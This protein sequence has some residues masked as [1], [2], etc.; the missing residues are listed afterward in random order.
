VTDERAPARAQARALVLRYFR[1]HDGHAD[2]AGILRDGKTL[3]ALGRA[4]AEPFADG[5]VCGV[6]AVESRGFVLGAL[7]AR[8]LGVG[9]VLARRPGTVHPGVVRL[10][11]AGPD[12]RGRPVDL[13][14]T[15]TAVSAGGRFLVVDDWIETG[16][17]ARTATALLARLGASVVGTSVLIDGT[18]P[19]VR[20]ALGVVG[21]LRADELPPDDVAPA[22]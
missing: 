12:W 16:A 20:A 18:S 5:N 17:H 14:V 2:L 15:G 9:L 22:R 1:W 7:V 6:V 8:Q 19:D 4:L 3:E 11:D 10:A 13:G 21:L